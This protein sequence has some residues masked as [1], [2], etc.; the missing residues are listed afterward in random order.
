MFDN[1]RAMSAGLT[2]RPARETAADTLAW[3]L[4]RPPGPLR[5]GA[6]WAGISREREAQVLAAWRARTSGGNGT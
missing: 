1:G 3:E 4:A 6:M 5:E 2:F